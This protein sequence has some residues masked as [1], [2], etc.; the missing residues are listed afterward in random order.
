MLKSKDF[1]P[2][3]ERF[4]KIRNNISISNLFEFYKSGEL[5]LL[6]SC[7]EADTKFHVEYLLQGIP[8]P[9]FLCY[10]AP[11]LANSNAYS[12]IPF[13]QTGF[14]RSLFDFMDNKVVIDNA[15]SFPDL[16]GKMYDFIKMPMVYQQKIEMVE[17]YS[18]GSNH[19]ETCVHLI[20]I[21]SPSIT[22]E[23]IDTINRIKKSA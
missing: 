10:K 12:I 15:I 6:D 19:L 9:S 17:C 16:N 5:V 11:I 21:V 14:L 13:T 22:D 18:Y 2:I 8:M 1:Q 20:N 7:S 3:D 4:S 23:F